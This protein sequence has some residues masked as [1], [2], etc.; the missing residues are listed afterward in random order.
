MTLAVYPGAP[1]HPRAIEGRLVYGRALGLAGNLEAGVEQ[2]AR[3]VRDATIVFGPTSRMVGFF[4]LPLARFELDLGRVHES[5][6]HSE[7]ALAIVATQSRPDSF[8]Y[9]VALHTRGTAL[10]AARRPGDAL[11]PLAAAA[12]TVARALSPSHLVT[13]AFRADHALALAAAGRPLEAARVLDPPAGP[14]PSGRTA[15]YS[16]YVLGVVARLSGRPAEALRSQ[17][18]ALQ[19]L[20][21]GRSADVD[22]LRVLTETGSAQLAL[23][24]PKSAADAFARSLAISRER[25]NPGPDR[26]E[27]LT[28]L[29][30]ALIRLHRR[31]EAAALQR[32][33]A[34]IWR[35][36][37]L[38]HDHRRD[39]RFAS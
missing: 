32:E 15:G 4:S 28:G 12:D 29:G 5:L 27:A 10:L 38:A 22:R 21:A 23:G 14:S 39:A 36:L 25:Q 16:F 20:P 31:G 6:E 3:A 37:D 17:Q 24:Q 8:R 9:A 26:A 30:R 35:R 11:A 34:E 19:A 18:R 33:A 13:R 1:R 7:R 2:L